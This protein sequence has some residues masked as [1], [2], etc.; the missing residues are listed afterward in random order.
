MGQR[1]AMGP[2]IP[3]N[4]PQ[5][6]PKS[7]L[8]KA[9]VQNLWGF[10]VFFCP[11]LPPLSFISTTISGGNGDSGIGIGIGTACNRV[12]MGVSPIVRPPSVG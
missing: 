11:P 12:R 8:K 4:P 9:A 10:G 1:D 6:H 7:P 2:Q 5:I 3:P